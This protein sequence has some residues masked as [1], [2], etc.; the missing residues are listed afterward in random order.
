MG[1]GPP[2][3]GMTT[4][5][6]VDA[7][8]DHVPPWSLAIAAMLVIQV[9]AA[10]STS[11]FATVGPA[12]TGWLRLTAGA[13]ILLV[14][15][16]P[17]L[18]GRSRRELA[19]AVALGAI[20]GAMN[21]SFLAALARIPLGTT[22]TIEFLGPLT[23]A[24]LGTRNP[25]RLAW[26]ALGLV[27]V[28][29]LTNPWAGTNGIPID[30]VGV[31]FA[32][33]AGVGWALY[34]VLTARVGDA[35]DGLEGLSVTIPIAAVV[36]TV[37][38]APGAIGSVT[39]GAVLVAVGIAVLQPF[40]GFSLELLALRRLT[41]SAF[42]TLMALEPAIG[43]VVGALLLGQQAGVSQALGVALVVIAGIGATRGGYRDRTGLNVVAPLTE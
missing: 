28:L 8:A 19:I 33:G 31:L 13:V 39:M 10:L 7:A 22:V 4:P 43:L 29:V 32:I 25:W 27:G 2:P 11:L 36:A 37:L 40:V 5:S 6:R 1:R 14:L 9:A 12:G 26:P 21:L 18:R 16:R 15:R 41:T 24:V 20:T 17:R 30:P 34:I 35:F 3:L 23:V 38:A 42:G